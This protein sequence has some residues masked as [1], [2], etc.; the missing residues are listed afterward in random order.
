MNQTLSSEQ[1]SIWRI[2]ST[3]TAHNSIDTVKQ[4]IMKWGK[5]EIAIAMTAVYHNWERTVW[6]LKLLPI[7]VKNLSS[8]LNHS[9]L[10]MKLTVIHFDS[11]YLAH[12]ELKR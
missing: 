6:D 8:Q 3:L 1:Y 7:P 12:R 11:F 5:S 9:E 2:W 10:T 4:K